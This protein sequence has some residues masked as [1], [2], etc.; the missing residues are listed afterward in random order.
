MERICASGWAVP[1]AAGVRAAESTAVVRL[2]VDL[3]AGSR[4]SLVLRL[5]GG[6]QDSSV[7]ICSDA[8]AE[9]KVAFAS[10]SSQV[11]VLPCVVDERRMVTARLLSLGGAFSGP[12]P[13]MLLGI[14]YLQTPSARPA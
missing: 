4:L 2:C 1:E 9:T 13:W 6:A 11:A 7:R 8:G 5:E 14:L 3:P 10:G 12:S